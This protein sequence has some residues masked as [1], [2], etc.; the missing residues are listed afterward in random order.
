MGFEEGVAFGVMLDLV[1][2]FVGRTVAFDDELGVMAVEVAEV[3]AELMLA[4]E[5]GIAELAVTQEFPK[6]ILGG[7]LLLPHLT[8]EFEQAREIVA[9]PVVFTPFSRW[10]KGWG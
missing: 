5:L 2:F 6:Q 9:S 7:C 8:R 3:I 4:T 10:E 1:W